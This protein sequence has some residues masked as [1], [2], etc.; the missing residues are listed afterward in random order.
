MI[1]NI[2]RK[3]EKKESEKSKQKVH[4]FNTKKCIFEGEHRRTQQTVEQRKL[5]RNVYQI[6]QEERRN[7]LEEIALGDKP[8]Q[9]VEYSPN[10]YETFGSTVPVPN[11]GQGA[12][13]TSDT[14]IPLLFPPAELGVSYREKEM[15]RQY[16]ESV[17]EVEKL[18]SWTAA[19]PLLIYP[20]K[21]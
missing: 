20:N 21:N 17:E 1:A 8:Y 16:V 3:S 13:D 18:S 19:P 5:L 2:G 11:F 6:P 14:F 9:A 10:F 12:S 4:H 7:G 15:A